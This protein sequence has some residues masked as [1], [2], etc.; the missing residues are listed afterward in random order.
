MFHERK[1]MLVGVSSLELCRGTDRPVTRTSWLTSRHSFSFGAYYD[2]DN[3][4]FGLLVSHNEDVLSAGSGFAM[5][6]HRGVEIVTWIVS[7]RLQ[8]RDSSGRAEVIESGTVQV[9]S[10]G[11][12]VAHS[13]YADGGE[14]AHYVQMWVMSAAEQR[15]HSYRVTSVEP[16]TAAPALIPVASG[17][18]EH[19]GIAPIEIAQPQAAFLVASLTAGDEVELPAS[20]FVHVF[21]ARGSAQITQHDGS[22]VGH[23]WDGRVSAGD[24]ARVTGPARTVVIASEYT[25]LL[26]WDMR[27]DLS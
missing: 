16:R 20:P 25:D 14:P 9:I 6:E 5:H 11:A 3:I 4:H 12:G 7:G 15:E 21:L 24:A 27:C 13:E 26:V 10:A 23:D 22:R 2:P 18:A 17:L 19:A 1:N 8:H